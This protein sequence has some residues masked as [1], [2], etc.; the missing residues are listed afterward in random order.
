MKIR[1]EKYLSDWGGLEEDR[2]HET[3]NS[4]LSVQVKNIATHEIQLY[5]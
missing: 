4:S 1:N 2:I 5:K 3:G